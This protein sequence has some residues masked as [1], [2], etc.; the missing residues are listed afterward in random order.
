VL[1]PRHEQFLDRRRV[2]PAS[3][4]AFPLCRSAVGLCRIILTPLLTTP[5]DRLTKVT[6]PDRSTVEL[7]DHAVRRIDCTF[8]PILCPDAAT[9]AKPRSGRL[10]GFIQQVYIPPVLSDICWPPT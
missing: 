8:V 5:K 10:T 2:L 7:K 3:S 4:A 9:P 6:L 1:P